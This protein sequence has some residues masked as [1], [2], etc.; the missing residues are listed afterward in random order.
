MLFFFA[1]T[2][3][4]SGSVIREWGWAGEHSCDLPMQ[5]VRRLPTDRLSPPP[6][7]R[8]M[9]LAPVRLG[10]SE[11]A[12]PSFPC[13]SSPAGVLHIAVAF[14]SRNMTTTLEK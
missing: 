9:A 5:I 7:H 10:K 11:A 1:P 2:A 6:R 3:P 4:G 14:P 13:Q 12:A 8:P